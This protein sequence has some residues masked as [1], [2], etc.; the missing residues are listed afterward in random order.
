[1]FRRLQRLSDAV[2]LDFEG[3]TLRAR[4]GEI[5]AAALLAAGIVALRETSDRGEARGPWCMIGNCFECRVEIDGEPN[6]Q[7]CLVR[8]RAG[9]RV[10]RQR[11]RRDLEPGDDG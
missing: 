7:A 9:M 5:L 10:R 11:G 2:E 6:Q 8:V 3:E 1:M 4:E